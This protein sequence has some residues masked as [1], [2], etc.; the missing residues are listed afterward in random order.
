[1]SFIKD[2]FQTSASKDRGGDSMNKKSQAEL[3]QGTGLKQPSRLDGQ[4][5]PLKSTG[6]PAPKSSL[7]YKK[8][9]TKQKRVQKGDQLGKSKMGSHEFQLMKPEIQGIGPQDIISRDDLGSSEEKKDL[10]TLAFDEFA[11]DVNISSPGRKP[12]NKATEL[13]PTGDSQLTMVPAEFTF[14]V[15]DDDHM[16]R[17]T[18]EFFITNYMGSFEPPLK[19]KV[20]NFASGNQVI[21]HFSVKF[22]IS[23]NNRKRKLGINL[24]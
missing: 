2:D 20:L 11:V 3:L 1:M 23:N 6:K 17:R 24:F 12:H 21:D 18:M 9:N 5:S 19:Y 13:P 16:C 22:F 10:N 14:A 15:L 4:G 7:Q 8:A